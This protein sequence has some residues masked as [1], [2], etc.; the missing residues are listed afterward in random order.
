MQYD[1]QNELSRKSFI[2]RVKHLLDKGRFVE[3]TDKKA[4]TLSQNN[5]LHMAIG[6][7]A[8]ETGNSLETIKRE[9]FKK[10]VN[11]DIFVEEKEDPAI[12]HIEVLRSSAKVSKE[13]MT[14]A[15]D[16]F[17]QFCSQLG[18][19]IPEPGEEELIR[20]AEYEIARS[21]KYFNG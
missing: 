21:E 11:P 6:L 3:L 7:L 9:V 18:V 17:I 4:R 20:Q 2:A 1:L 8:I 15:I 12:G 14:I 10:K 19:Y 13:E 16:R 5:Y